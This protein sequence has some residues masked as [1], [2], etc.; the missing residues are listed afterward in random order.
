MMLTKLEETDDKGKSKR[1]AEQY[2]PELDQP[3][4]VLPRS[5]IRVEQ[6]PH[7]RSEQGGYILR[8]FL[9]TRG[10]NSNAGTG[11]IVNQLQATAWP[12]HSVPESPQLI[13]DLVSEANML[14]PSVT[15]PLLVHCSAG[16]GRTGTFIAAHKLNRDLERSVESLEVARTVVE[17]RKCRMKMVQTADQYVHIYQ[18]LQELY[19]QRQDD[20]EYDD[21]DYGDYYSYSNSY[22]ENESIV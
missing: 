1:K 2:W 12:D 18:C 11:T 14:S 5:H 16:V 7:K 6:L 17:M 13:L 20:D 3:S 9:V 4:L 22:Y 15:S 19:N 10:S 21:E 8:K